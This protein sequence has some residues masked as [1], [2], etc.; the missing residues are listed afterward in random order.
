MSYSKNKLQPNSVLFTM[1]SPV[2]FNDVRSTS[3]HKTMRV[4][5][6]YKCCN[7]IGKNEQYINHQFRYDNRIITISF[8]VDCFNGL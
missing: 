5:Q 2:V 8:H 1:L 6:C 4:R 3:E 7:K